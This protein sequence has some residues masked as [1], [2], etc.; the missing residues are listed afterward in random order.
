MKGLIFI[1]ICFFSSSIIAQNTEYVSTNDSRID[2][3]IST[4]IK[5]N[6]SKR[7]VDGYRVQIHHNKSQSR[8]ESEKVRAQF[9]LDFPHL[10]TY[11]KFISP[12]YKIQVGNFLNKLDAYKVKK[13]I[14]R[15]YKGPYIVPATV[16]FE[17]VI[18]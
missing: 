16:Q 18:N 13:E 17:D 4:Q 12:Y 8:E 7:G 11:L 6:K 14:S 3:L 9:S 5:L 10:K 1:M 2:S 15:K